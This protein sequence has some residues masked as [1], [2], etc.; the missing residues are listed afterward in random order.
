MLSSMHSKI[1][2]VHNI[3]EMSVPDVPTT[4]VTKDVSGNP[5][6]GLT[7]TLTCVITDGRPRDDITKVTWKKGD[8]TLQ[9]SSHYTLSDKDKVLT[10]SP[11]NHTLDDGHYSCAADN[12][13]GKGAFSA[14]LHLL[15]N[16][17][18]KIHNIFHT[19]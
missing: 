14:K 2:G 7:V 15:V 12:K 10:I 1:I 11:L 13:A 3:D 18:C 4:R 8:K 9:V 17:K 16:C 5:T 6:E 19:T